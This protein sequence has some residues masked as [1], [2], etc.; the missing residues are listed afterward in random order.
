MSSVGVLY[1]LGINNC[2]YPEHFADGS[3][4]PK[5]YID[6]SLMRQGV[7]DNFLPICWW[8]EEKEKRGKK[9]PLVPAFPHQA[10]TPLYRSGFVPG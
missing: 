9:K 1:N 3:T 8:S 10:L 6:F 2:K 7:E 4:R 5:K